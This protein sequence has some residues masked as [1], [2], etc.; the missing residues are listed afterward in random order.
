[1][2]ECMLS[3][4]YPG[5]QFEVVNAGMVAINSHVVR[6]IARD[7]ARLEPDA[8]IV[9]MGNNEVVGPYGPGTA[10]H[11]FSSSLAFIRA[12]IALRGTRIGQALDLL[13]RLPSR[14]GDRAARWNGMQQFLD[15]RVRADDPQLAIAYRHFE[16]NLRDIV[17]AGAGAGAR[18]LLCT[19][20][21]NLGTSPPFSATDEANAAFREAQRF[22]AAG[23]LDKALAR[24]SDARDL[25]TLRFRADS[26]INAAIRRVAGEQPGSVTLVDVENIFAKASANGIPGD[27]LFLEHVH[28]NFHGNYVLA[29][30][31]TDALST[32]FPAT[33]Q[34]RHAPKAQLSEADCARLLAFTV[35]NRFALDEDVYR[36]LGTPPFTFQLDH[37]ARAAALARDL[38]GRREAAGPAGMAQARRE[39]AE[40][41]RR[42]PNDW[43]LHQNFGNL[44]MASGDLAGAMREYRRVFELIPHAAEPYMHD[45]FALADKGQLEEGAVLIMTH[46]PDRPRDAA[47]A[48]FQLGE[49]FSANGDHARAASLLKKAVDLEPANKAA[50]YQLA[51][52]LGQQGR[53]PE[54][55]AEFN[56]L[57][58]IDPD[59][60][61]AH[62]NLAMALAGDERWDEA[63]RHLE[64]VVEL[65]PRDEE[66]RAAL[67]AARR[68]A[69]TPPAN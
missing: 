46:N 62:Y 6:H 40:A 7:V 26:Q 10:F 12:G 19:I 45:A 41:L 52:A 56:A 42:D 25:D 43:D 3:A 69:A 49:V 33:V 39:Y 22:E 9:Y 17:N 32:G 65:D 47:E 4:E 57:L 14:T 16:R 5:V 61:D 13:L 24:F 34:E 31:L 44:L 29:K 23:R 1:M 2:M 21:V 28:M 66:A 58:A 18:V 30:A 37:E 8:Y 68:A 50:R 53:Q 36:R 27:D 64:R 11:A 38:D 51:L 15:H 67:G 60:A 20:G 59:N 54:A 63:I 48:Y 35:W 55:I